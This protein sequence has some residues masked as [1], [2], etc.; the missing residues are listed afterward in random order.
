MQI[1]R[2]WSY[3]LIVAAFFVA[4]ALYCML[5]AS[6]P[7]DAAIGYVSTALG[8]LAALVPILYIVRTGPPGRRPAAVALYLVAILVGFFLALALVAP[9]VRLTQ[10]SA[11]SRLLLGF[12]AALQAW[13]LASSALTRV[14][15]AWLASR[16]SA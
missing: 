2:A 4:F 6:C 7:G 16:K 8:L 10:D 9:L 13:P 14:G 12:G 1:L 15:I 5:G 3:L 11:H